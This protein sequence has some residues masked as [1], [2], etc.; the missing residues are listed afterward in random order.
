MSTL[1]PNYRVTL[2]QTTATGIATSSDASIIVEAPMPESFVFDTQANYAPM[3]P[4]GLTGGGV[5]TALAAVG[6]RLAVPA[7]TAQLW[8]GSSEI[9]L[10]LALEFH[11]ESDP[12]ADVQTPILNLNRLTMPSINSS[13]GMLQSPG[14]SINFSQ[15]STI[16]KGAATSISNTAS[17]IYNTVTGS[18]SSA[19]N[20]QPSTMNNSS[21]TANSGNGTA[22]T[23]SSTQNPQLGTSAYWKTQISNQISIR[24]GNYLYFDSVVITNVQQTFMSNIDAITGL[25]HHATVNIT[26]KPLFML[27]VEDLAS[28]FISNSSPGQSASANTTSSN[29][30]GSSLSPAANFALLQSGTTIT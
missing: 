5:A 9:Q 13:S 28:V 21:L 24:V 18:G 2:M 14:P 20:P 19:S 11:T 15:L 25:P 8:Q 27:T 30:L 26:F 17:S 4:Q 16:A 12:V 6:I 10:Q 22:V 3:L 1:N 23:Q 7:L 29:S